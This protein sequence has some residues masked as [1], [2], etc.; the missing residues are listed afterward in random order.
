MG[1]IELNGFV[2]K[3][4]VE[5][6]NP[7]LKRSFVINNKGTIKYRIDMFLPG[8]YFYIWHPDKEQY[9]EVQTNLDMTEK[10]NIDLLLSSFDE[11]ID[12]GEI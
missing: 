3:R 7:Q 1:N 10:E 11:L 9:F 6:F 2:F 4:W 8:D 12:G 5:T